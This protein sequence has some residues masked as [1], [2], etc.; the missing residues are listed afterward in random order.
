VD[1]E[2]R[3][4]LDQEQGDFACRCMPRTCSVFVEAPGRKRSP[5]H[6]EDPFDHFLQQ[7]VAFLSYM[8]RAYYELGRPPELQLVKFG[9][10]KM[11]DSLDK[12]LFRFVR[13]GKEDAYVEAREVYVFMLERYLIDSVL[14]R[15]RGLSQR[16]MRF[17]TTEEQL[18]EDAP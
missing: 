12:L 13:T 8:I 6:G 17:V 2:Q 4:V 18:G 15:F 16:K 7:R 11:L 9:S 5:A 1:Q 3:T 10:Q 14:Q